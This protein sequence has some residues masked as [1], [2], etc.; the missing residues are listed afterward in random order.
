MCEIVMRVELEPEVA[1]RVEP[2][3]SV[4]CSSILFF[5]TTPLGAL[6]GCAIE[7]AEALSIVALSAD[8]SMSLLE[9]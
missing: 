7:E 4:R 8:I 9:G 6:E 5:T 1:R 2:E 3:E